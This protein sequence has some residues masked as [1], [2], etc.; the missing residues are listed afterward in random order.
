MVQLVLVVVG[1]GCLLVAR[2]GG[3]GVAGVGGPEAVADD[4]DF[5]E[6]VD[7]D[8]GGQSERAGDG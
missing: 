2:R 5:G 8:D 6:L 1:C 7:E 4:D 3:R